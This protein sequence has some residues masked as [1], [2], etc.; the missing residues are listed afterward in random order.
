MLWPSSNE[1]EVEARHPRRHLIFFIVSIALLMASVDQMIVATALSP[2]QRELHTGVQWGG[3]VITVYALG[4]VLIMPIAGKISDMYGRRRI[5]L[6]AAVIFTVASL[7]CGLSVNIYMIV[8]MRAVQAIGGG[9]F[10][11][12]AT[13]LVSDHYG[14]GRDRAIGM[15]SSIFPIGG[16]IGPA[17]GGIIVT[18]TSWRWIFLVNVPIGVVLIVLGVIFFPKNVPGER[19]R[20]D[21]IGIIA[22]GAAII[23]GML[24]ITYL[25]AAG[26]NLLSPFFLVPELVA[27]L[28]LA[29]FVRHSRRA[30][31]AF[32]PA[33]L[34][35]G[36]G[37]GSMN[38]LNFLF[39][40]AMLGLSALLPLYAQERFGIPVLGA[41]TLLT[42]RATGMI[43]I[44]AIATFMLRRTGY[45][46]PMFIGFGAIALGLGLIALVP[47]HVPVYGWLA[48]GACVTGLGMGLSLPA[49]NNASLHL[50]PLDVAA[51]SGL[52]GMFRQAGG[53]AAVSVATAIAARGSS[54]GAAL[55]DIFLAFAAILVLS[56]PL[57]LRVPEHRGSW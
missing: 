31:S 42:A 7:L 57:I 54:P 48:I 21:L 12:A 17:L 11:P 5:F 20:F 33:E 13:G 15:F 3:W 24:G 55:G 46:I 25:G 56:M 29:F 19:Q 40:A 2:I 18:F 22:L 27:V 49:S 44:A 28:A 32:I 16:V 53:I 39:G 51:V 9:A 10:I 8:A 23:G 38:A 14:A 41:G 1:T 35:L 26:S 47:P 34:L 36:G 37:F 52:R 6:L 50:R 30:P 43:L 45:R 4:Q